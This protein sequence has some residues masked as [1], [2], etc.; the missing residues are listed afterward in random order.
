MRKQVIVQVLRGA[1]SVRHMP[2]HGRIQTFLRKPDNIFMLPEAHALLL[3]P[4]NKLY[5]KIKMLNSA[6]QSVDLEQLRQRLAKLGVKLD[7]GSANV[8]SADHDGSSA[9]WESHLERQA[10]LRHTI[11]NITGRI[12]CEPL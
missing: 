3:K 2:C 10:K 4:F 6:S 12:T 8:Q 1:V 11:E 9:G 5:H 7:S